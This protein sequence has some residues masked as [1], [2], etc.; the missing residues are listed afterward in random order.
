MLLCGRSVSLLLWVG[1]ASHSGTRYAVIQDYPPRQSVTIFKVQ[2]G[3]LAKDC[4]C[5]LTSLLEGGGR[6]GQGT[7]TSVS[8]HLLQSTICKF[9]LTFEWLSLGGPMVC[10]WRM[11]EGLH[12]LSHGKPSSLLGAAAPSSM[13]ALEAPTLLPKTSHPLLCSPTDSLVSHG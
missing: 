9:H 4:C 7:L 10:R 2:L 8:S 6:D 1:L 5:F 13:V 3:L 11:R 12:V